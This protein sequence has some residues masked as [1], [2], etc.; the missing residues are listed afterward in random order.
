M[1]TTEYE[2]ETFS[3]QTIRLDGRQFRRCTFKNCV[4]DV[5]GTAPI[6]LEDCTLDGCELELNG[7]AG[8]AI[9]FLHFLAQDPGSAHLVERVIEQIRGSA[10]TDTPPMTPTP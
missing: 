1:R 7:P 6:E 8:L 5:H 2:D 9:E 3:H 4:L 10:S